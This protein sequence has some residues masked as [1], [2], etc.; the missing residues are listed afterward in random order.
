[1]RW[2][3]YLSLPVFLLAAC[4]GENN[5]P[6]ASPQPQNTPVLSP[7]TGTEEPTITPFPTIEGE[8]PVALPRTL[9]ASE[10]E[11]PNASIPFRMLVLTRTGGADDITLN[12]EI[13][14]TGVMM[15]D[16]REGQI[17]QAGLDRL[18][19]LIR[20]M[21]FFGAQNAYLPAIPLSGPGEE[22]IYS[23]TIERAGEERTITA[24][25][26]YMPQELQT[27]IAEVITQSDAIRR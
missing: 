17:S 19:D 4:S 20:R 3:V 26:G 16:E 10:T 24:M 9:V 25:E 18:N 14:G 6:T 21:N 8:L 12:I 15:R 13:R 27:L 11:D 7:Q 1:M 5:A 22:F 23:M 2:I